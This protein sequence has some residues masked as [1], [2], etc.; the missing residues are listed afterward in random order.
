MQPRHLAS[1]LAF[2]LALVAAAPV[3]AQYRSTTGRGRVE[4]ALDHAWGFG[5]EG[6][7][8]QL[9]SDLRVYAPFGF[10]AVF[11]AGLA[12]QLLSNALAFDLGVAQRFD[13]VAGPRAGL[14][15]ALAVGG[16]YANGPFAP[17]SVASLPFHERSVDAL[18]GFAMVHLDVWIDT[19]FF[20]A[21][22]SG[23]LLR[24]T[25][26][27]HQ[28]RGGELLTSVAPTLRLG[29]EWGL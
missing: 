19:F 15:L 1:L 20:G 14:Q 18:G 21:G 23:H 3:C 26:D 22:V 9:A 13:L 17:D 28:A 29:G 10:G 25:G 8:L 12:S 16:S 11:R 24:A 6:E 5:S 7:H 27:A 4:I 2:G